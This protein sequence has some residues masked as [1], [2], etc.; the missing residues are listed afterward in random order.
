MKGAEVSQATFAQQEPGVKVILQ[1]CTCPKKNLVYGKIQSYS[2]PTWYSENRGRFQADKTHST[3]T[4][5]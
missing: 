4:I 3:Q 5:Y 1:A 2:C